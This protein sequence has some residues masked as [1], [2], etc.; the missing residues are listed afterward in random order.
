VARP[1][2]WPSQH[3]RFSASSVFPRTFILTVS[4]CRSKPVTREK[5][6]RKKNTFSNN[7]NI[8]QHHEK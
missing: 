5:K 8:I 6:K 7:N 1:P 3:A 2:G 4:A